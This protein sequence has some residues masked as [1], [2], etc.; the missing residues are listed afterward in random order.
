MAESVIKVSVELSA[1]EARA[2][3]Q[4]LKRAGHADYVR[5]SVKG[6]KEEPFLMLYAADKLRR[7]FAEAG[8][9]PR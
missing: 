7:A 3:A 6:D 1:E 8:I 4:F 5:F 2:F 9:A